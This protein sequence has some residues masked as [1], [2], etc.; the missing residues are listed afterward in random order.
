M[1]KFL[2][3]FLWLSGFIWGGIG[4]GER[5]FIGKKL[6]NLGSYI[7]WGLWVSLYIY[8]IGLSSG[9]YIFACLVSVF[10]LK[11]FS[12]LRQVSLLVSLVTLL[13]GLLAVVLDL[14]HWERFWYVFRYPTLSSM[15]SWMVWIYSLYFLIVIIQLYYVL[16]GSLKTSRLIFLISFPLAVA[17]PVCG[18]SLFGVI[19]ARPCIGPASWCPSGS[20]T[21]RSSSSGVSRSS[22]G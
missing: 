4:V 10:K 22:N 15:M 3:I 21:G 17:I 9:S 8:L 11:S 2:I 1:G 19:G 13:G 16:S 6:L 12:R 14:G 5:L 18:G 20:P 7:S